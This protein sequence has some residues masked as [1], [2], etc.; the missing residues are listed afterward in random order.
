M[1]H[2]QQRHLVML[3]SLLSVSSSAA[4][5]SSLTTSSSYS[6]VI[7]SQSFFQ[8]SVSRPISVC[9]MVRNA[10]ALPSFFFMLTRDVSNSHGRSL[11][12]K[13]VTLL[14][15]ILYQLPKNVSLI[16]CNYAILFTNPCTPVFFLN[17]PAARCLLWD[18]QTMS[19]S[20][21][22]WGQNLVLNC[23]ILTHSS[24]FDYL[25][26]SFTNIC[27]VFSFIMCTPVHVA[28]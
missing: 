27:T 8:P 3:S 5:T 15:S 22:A 2:P 4:P 16:F 25:R 6:G 11:A 14:I 18:R 13:A 26:N 9:W 23:P 17:T 10:C 19:S 28:L 21:C 20:G 12:N 1:H 24:S 7:S